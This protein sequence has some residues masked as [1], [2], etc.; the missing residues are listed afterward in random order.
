MSKVFN[1]PQCDV[2][3]DK[4]GNAIIK[5]ILY[6]NFPADG[7]DRT[8][9]I[10]LYPTKSAIDVKVKGSTKET[11]QKF[12]DKGQRNGANFFVDEILPT[13]MQS[14]Y[15]SNDISKVKK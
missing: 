15:K 8:L 5:D 12:E 4:Y 3:K 10:T 14:L 2:K 6:F 13:L 9:M 7:K 1:F 11:F